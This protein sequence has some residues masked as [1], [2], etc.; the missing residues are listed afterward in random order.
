[1]SHSAVHVAVLAVFLSAVMGQSA[2][3]IENEDLGLIT[4]AGVE[5]LGSLVCDAGEAEYTVTEEDIFK[6]IFV[7]P[8]AG[9]GA[10]I[11]T[12][13]VGANSAPDCQ[14]VRLIKKFVKA[15]KFED[16]GFT[17]WYDNVTN[18]LTHSNEAKVVVRLRTP[19]PNII[20]RKTFLVPLNCVGA[21]SA[22]VS[23]PTKWF[24]Q[25]FQTGPLF[26]EFGVSVSVKIRKE[27]RAE[28]FGELDVFVN[29]L[30]VELDRPYDETY[31]IIGHRVF[32]TPTLNQ[33]STPSTEFVSSRGCNYYPD[34][35]TVTKVRTD[36][37]IYEILDFG[38]D[39][40]DD[41]YFHVEVN[42]CAKGIPGSRVHCVETC[43]GSRMLRVND[44]PNKAVATSGSLSAMG[45]PRLIIG[46]N[47]VPALTS[48][49]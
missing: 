18:V 48:R 49:K 31:E 35:V 43:V 16:C 24:E 29:V 41:Y 39:D 33:T 11:E 22:V 1:M 14:A 25:F 6:L 15:T 17:S 8:A 38:F 42:L 36:K 27:H 21:G 20:R 26:Q 40:S 19:S 45:V 23:V 3:R 34:F 9:R 4:R 28:A 44:A 47:G 13:T 5:A 7:N 46:S 12:V 10:W 30:T 2:M 37:F 32:T